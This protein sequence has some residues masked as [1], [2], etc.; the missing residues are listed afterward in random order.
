[1][2]EIY[3]TAEAIDTRVREL[4]KQVRG[5]GGAGT[6]VLTGVL[7]GAV[8]FFADL[9]RAI[10]GPTE[11]AFV[12]ARSY[13]AGTESSR[14]VEVDVVGPETL[15]A[16]DVV[17]IDTI[18]DTGHTLRTVRDR[19]VEAGAASVLTCVLLDKPS[20]REIEMEAD[21]VGFTV[22]DRFLIGYGLDHAGQHRG[23]RDLAVL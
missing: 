2:T 4:G 6:L 7:K 3:L 23:L 13:G 8:L 10:V 15:D 21:L 22:P 18:L 16:R 12:R 9:A 14:A 11:F 5:R 19:I 1:M 17:L 20:R